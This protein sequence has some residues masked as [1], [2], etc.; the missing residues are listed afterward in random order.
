MIHRVRVS[1]WRMNPGESCVAQPQ[2][3]Q[4]FNA[5]GLGAPAA[6]SPGSFGAGY[7]L[8]QVVHK[9]GRVPIQVQFEMLLRTQD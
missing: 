2:R 3:A 9:R 1:S 5:L 4:A 7:E 6:P 8:N